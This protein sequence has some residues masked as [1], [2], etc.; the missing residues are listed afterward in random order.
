[1]VVLLT[2]MLVGLA[3]MTEFFIAWYSGDRYEQ[4]HFLNRF[5][6]PSGW[7]AWIM[8]GCNMGVPQLLWFKA[9]RRNLF[10]VFII[11]LLVNLGMWFE[12][13]VIIVSSLQADYLP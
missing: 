6:G 13:W 9:V 3:Y 4:F 11:S 8:Y 7:W 1:K 10:V 12:R 5:L 2:S